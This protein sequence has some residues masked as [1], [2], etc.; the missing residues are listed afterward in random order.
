MKVVQ[1]LAKKIMIRNSRWPPCP[2]N[3]QWC[4]RGAIQDH[5]GPFVTSVYSLLSKK[6]LELKFVISRKGG[7]DHHICAREHFCD[8][9]FTSLEDETLPRRSLVLKV[10]SLIYNMVSEIN[11]LTKFR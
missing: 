10:V 1:N 3:W 5:Y 8:F 6:Y 9:L 2:Y 11:I 7:V 4:L